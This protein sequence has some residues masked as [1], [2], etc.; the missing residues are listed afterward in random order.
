M[1]V[2]LILTS[3]VVGMAFSVLSLVQKHMSSIQHNF[4]NNT[5]LSLLEQS[6]NLDF[7]RYSNISYD[8]L[9]E[10]LLFS[11]EIDSVIYE[12]KTEKI[13]KNLD[14]FNIRIQHKALF[15]D[16]EKV[17]NGQIDAIKLQTSKTFQNQ[18]LFVFKQNDATLFMN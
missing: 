4:N 5:E 12:F 15:F 10:R 3:I 16:G 13:I 6:L 17:Q 2:V 11:S 7:N 9:N 1:V 8:A 14:S 18:Q